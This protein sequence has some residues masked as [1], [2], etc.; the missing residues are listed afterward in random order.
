MAFDLELTITGICAF[1]QN[2]ITSGRYRVCVVMP[3]TDTEKNALDDEP[4]CR[5]E[6]CIEQGYGFARTKTSIKEQR[7]TFEYQAFESNPPLDRLPIATY[8]YL[9]LLNLKDTGVNNPT[10]PRMV[11]FSKPPALPVMAQIFL[12]N[13]WLGL[14]DPEGHWTIAPGDPHGV[15]AAHEVIITLRGLERARAILQPFD[16]SRP[17]SVDLT[18]STGIS[19]V[20]VRFVNACARSTSYPTG[21]AWRDRDFKWY[22]ELLENPGS[23]I[24]DNEDLQ[25]PRF[26]PPP[27]IGGNN[28]FPARLEPAPFR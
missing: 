8:D 11:S 17:T 21:G 1:M 10:D 16:G 18:P 24:R 22:Y 4:L 12:D 14:S 15:L 2:E 3:S 26:V 23:I 9:G 19:T 20:A 7:V 5:H 27:L 6:C 25:I 13:G 28:C